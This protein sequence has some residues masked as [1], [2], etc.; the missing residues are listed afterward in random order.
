MSD[1]LSDG[2]RIRLLTV[3]DLY[4]RECLAIRANFRITGDQVVRVPEG[5]DWERASPT[6]L[7]VDNG[8]ETETG[9]QL[10]P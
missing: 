9:T 6:S 7:R 8:P 4:T 3:L 2:K 10:S 1:T 5:L